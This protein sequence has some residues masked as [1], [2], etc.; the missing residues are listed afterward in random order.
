ME[1]ELDE[2]NEMMETRSTVMDAAIKDD[3]AIII[4]KITLK[5]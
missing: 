4:I 1:I 5:F 2:K 3:A